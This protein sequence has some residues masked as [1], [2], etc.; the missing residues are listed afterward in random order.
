MAASTTVLAVRRIRRIG[1]MAV[2]LPKSFHCLPQSS[3]TK[4]RCAELR[5]IG[6]LGAVSSVSRCLCARREVGDLHGLLLRL[7][8]LSVAWL[9]R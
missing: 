1:S 4:L 9:L 8:L 5:R 3:P 2:P 6:C 7:W